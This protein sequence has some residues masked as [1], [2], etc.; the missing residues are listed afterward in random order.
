MMRIAR[1]QNKPLF[2][3]ASSR[4]DLKAFPGEV[5]S[6]VGFALWD[7][8]NGRTPHGA[9]PMKGFGGGVTVMELVAD[10]HTD[11]YR[12]VYTA[13]FA[14]AVFVLHCFQK[15]SK[16]GIAT[17]QADVDL[18]A[19]RLKEAARFYKQWKEQQDEPILKEGD[20]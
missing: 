4:K 15:K 17:T 19:A 7:V 11:T 8:Q 13:K 3:A 16:R 6:E 2:F 12:A 20:K 14:D 1:S 10:Y 5:Q 18:I 9:K